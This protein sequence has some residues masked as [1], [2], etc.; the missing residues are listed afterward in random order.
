MLSGGSGGF[1]AYIEYQFATGVYGYENVDGTVGTP[2]IPAVDAD[3]DPD[4]DDPDNDDE[5]TAG[6]ATT[7]TGKSYG[8]PQLLDAYITQDL[9]GMK[10]TMGRFKV[11]GNASAMEHERDMFF[12]TR[13][14]IGYH[15]ATRDEGVQLSGNSGFNWSVGIAN[16]QDDGQT[17]DD[18]D[19]RISLHGDMDFGGGLKGGL[20]YTDDASDEDDNALIIDLSYSMDNITFMAE[21]AN[22]AEGGGG[23][24]GNG[25]GSVF[26]Y[27][28]A[29]F[30]ATDAAGDADG[31]SPYSL[32]VTYGLGGDSSIGIRM[33]DA[34]NDAGDSSI[35]VAYNWSN[36]SIQ[37]ST[38]D[39]DGD[40]AMDDM[41]V[42]GCQVGF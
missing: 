29:A 15:Y 37:Y 27:T 26:G 35:D 1:G 24:T 18:S 13:S 38:F 17:A 22:I 10:L 8:G 41:L 12:A 9:G 42:V 34:D 19:Y 14:N 4:T 39:N 28:T 36:W 25:D 23:Y 11:V 40:T 31:S 33:Q 21:M 32:A 6:S 2:N 7:V 16:G 30:G 20:T 3:N 5:Y